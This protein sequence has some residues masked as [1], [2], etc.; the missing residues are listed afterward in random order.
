MNIGKFLIYADDA[1]ISSLPNP[2]T[3]FNKGANGRITDLLKPN[4]FD[5]ITTV[6]IIIGLLF[7]GNLV[8]AGW[9]YMLSSGDPKKVSAASGRL[10]NGITGLIMAFTA[11]LVVKIVTTIL[12]TG[13][14]I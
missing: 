3:N 9:E 5:V 4:G 1:N 7:F 11:Y 2:A 14:T 12:K 13:A 10:T 8:A 6:F